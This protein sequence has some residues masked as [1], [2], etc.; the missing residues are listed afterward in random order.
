MKTS[1]ALTT[2]LSLFEYHLHL[3]PPCEKMEIPCLSWILRLC[4]LLR[5]IP[6]GPKSSLSYEYA[7]AIGLSLVVFIMPKTMKWRRWCLRLFILNKAADHVSHWG[8]LCSDYAKVSYWC[9]IALIFT[10]G[11]ARVKFSVCMYSTCLC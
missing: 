10:C 7:M 8:L 3:S 4:T 11:T 6:M 2:H 1:R 9:I 5:I